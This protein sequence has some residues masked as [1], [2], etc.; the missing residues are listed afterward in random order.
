MSD[1]NRKTAAYFDRP[2]VCRILLLTIT[3]TMLI[4]L[5]LVGAELLFF[6][7][8]NYSWQLFPPHLLKPSHFICLYVSLC[9]DIFILYIISASLCWNRKLNVYLCWRYA[10]VYNFFQQFLSH[11]STIIYICVNDFFVFVINWSI[12]QYLKDVCWKQKGRIVQYYSLILF[13]IKT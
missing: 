7:P 12:L 3:V 2:I 10:K 8:G 13:W 5:R 1:I 4:T 9:S 6:I 11:S